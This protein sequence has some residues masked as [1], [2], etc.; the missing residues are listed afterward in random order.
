M[1]KPSRKDGETRKIDTQRTRQ[2][3]SALPSGSNSSC[4]ARDRP[5]RFHPDERLIPSAKRLILCPE[6]GFSTVSFERDKSV[7]SRHIANTFK[8]NELPRASTV[9]KNATVQMEGGHS[10]ERAIEYYNLDLTLSVGYCVSNG[11]LYWV[12]T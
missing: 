2:R 12:A 8:T 3:P 4:N 9:A 1:P 10:V 7:I 11:R 5:S 6:I